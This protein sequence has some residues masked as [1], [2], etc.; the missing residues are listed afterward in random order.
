MKLFERIW[1]VQID[2]V[3]FTELDVKFNIEKSLRPEPNKCHLEILNLAESSR[4]AIEK[5]NLYDPKKIKGVKPRTG[6]AKTEAK[7]LPKVG[8]I[9]VTV[10]AGY[11]ETGMSLLFRGD[12]RRAISEDDGEG[13]WTTK[14]EGEDGGTSILG[15][16]VTES[17]PSGT[18]RYQVV[19]ACAEAM[20]VGLGNI[21]E[22]ASDLQGSYS[23]GTV[24]DGQASE[25]LKGVLRSAKLKYSIQNGVLRLESAE[26]NEMVQALLLSPTTGLVGSPKRDSTGTLEVT[27]LLIPNLAPGGYVQLE[28]SGYKGVYK[29]QDIRYQ[30]ESAGTPWY[31]VLGLVAG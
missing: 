2:T 22:F 11:E 15:S 9:F 3:R 19:R 7:R 25:E 1:R 6:R 27:C 17:F 28:S 14:V 21:I 18:S 20:G 31:A 10:E 26:S 13:T 30:G 8:K 24:L 12:L 23:H 5:L 4:L 29:I 16:R